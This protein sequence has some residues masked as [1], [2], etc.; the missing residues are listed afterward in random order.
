MGKTIGSRVLLALALTAAGST[1]NAN[2]LVN[3]GFEDPNIATGSFQIFQSIAGWSK[4]F[5]SGIEIQDH[6]AGNP[7]EG[8][9]FVE[10][11]AHSNSGMAQTVATE[12]GAL[13]DL[14]FY[15]SPRP[16]VSILSNGITILWEGVIIDS[17]TA[18]GSGQTVWNQHAYQV[19]ATTTQSILE[20]QATGIS[21][22]L[23][24]YLDA[25]SLT[26]VPEPA[27]LA[28]LG[29]G[30]AGLGFARRRQG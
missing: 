24:G 2:L 8:D 16:N 6:V 18:A 11:D 10:L 1:A 22:S 25:A 27:S 4:T 29:L 13:Y 28:L 7:F 9:Q 15:F 30:L 3:G 17:I 20:F 21:D 12:I 26:K 5:G 19:T 14:S 23:G